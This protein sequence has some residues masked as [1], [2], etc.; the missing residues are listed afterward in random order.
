MSGLGSVVT[1]LKEVWSPSNDRTLTSQPGYIATSLQSQYNF[2]PLLSYDSSESV[3][4]PSKEQYPHSTC[5]CM[6]QC[7]F[8]IL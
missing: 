4:D 2:I 8:H 5:M 6:C 7:V 3:L 1:F